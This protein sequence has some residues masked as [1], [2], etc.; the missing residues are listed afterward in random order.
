[1]AHLTL[2]ILGTK[3]PVVQLPNPMVRAAG[4]VAQALKMPF[5]VDPNVI[6]YATLFWL[7]DN[8]KARMELGATFRSA[9]D[10]LAPTLAWLTETRR[11]GVPA[12]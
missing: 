10:T 6:P 11:I 1:L 12:R 5:P 3:R 8:Q 4:R 9:R 7:M 2:D